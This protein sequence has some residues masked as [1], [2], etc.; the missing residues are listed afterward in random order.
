[1]AFPLHMAIV[2]V[3]KTINGRFVAMTGGQKPLHIKFICKVIQTIVI[4][5]TLSSLALNCK[6]II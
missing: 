3:C 5:N 1:M 4:C 6:M 2:Y